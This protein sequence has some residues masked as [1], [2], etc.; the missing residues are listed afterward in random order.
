MYNAL[1]YRCSTIYR[2]SILHSVYKNIFDVF[3]KFPVDSFVGVNIKTQLG[4]CQNGSSTFI[5]VHM[6][7]MIRY[8][9]RASYTSG[10]CCPRTWCVLKYRA[11]TIWIDWKCVIRTY[12]IV[13]S[14]YVHPVSVAD[15]PVGKLRFFFS[16]WASTFIYIRVCRHAFN[17]NYYKL[18]FNFTSVDEKKIK[19]NYS[20]CASIVKYMITDNHLKKKKDELP[21]AK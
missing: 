2:W 1:N 16:R 12:D 14:R 10:R 19:Q 17:Q 4:Q 18:I 7:N 9:A 8:Y 15:G 5:F 3:S 21:R 13:H 11:D 6:Y 20:L